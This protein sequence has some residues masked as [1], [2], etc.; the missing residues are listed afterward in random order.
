MHDPNVNVRLAAVDAL[1]KF[2]ERQM[3]RN[4]VEQALNK[5]DS[6]LVQTALID[7]VVEM[8]QK[9]SLNTLRKLSKDADVNETVRKRAEWGVAHLE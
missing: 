8:Q 6:P 5:Q 3:V 4:G 1:K 2:G 7:Y 9:E